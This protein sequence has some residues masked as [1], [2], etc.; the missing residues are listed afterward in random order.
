MGFRGTTVRH[1][2]S[3][4]LIIVTNGEWLGLDD[5]T[6]PALIIRWLQVQVLQGPPE[7]S[8]LCNR[9]LPRRSFSGFIILGNMHKII[10]ALLLCLCPAILP[11]QATRDEGPA[12]PLAE[13]ILKRVSSDYRDQA[14]TLLTATEPR[15]AA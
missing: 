13:E 11:A 4:S 10:P 7:S 12:K 2:P 9:I 8:Q 5:A 15:Q 14:K 1:K 3:N 6:R